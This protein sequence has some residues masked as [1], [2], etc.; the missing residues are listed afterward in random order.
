MKLKIVK[1]LMNLLHMIELLVYNVM[2]VFIYK[3]IN[4]L[5]DIYQIVLYIKVKKFVHNVK[6]VI[7]HLVWKLDLKLIL[8]VKLIIVLKRQN[9]LIVKFLILVIILETYVVLLVNNLIKK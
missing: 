3:I 8:L 5:K 6:K 9:K 4:V 2:M 1:L 7:G